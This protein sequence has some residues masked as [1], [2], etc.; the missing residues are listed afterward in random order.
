MSSLEDSA[1][2]IAR[3]AVDAAGYEVVNLKVDGRR[4]MRIWIDHDPDGVKVDDCV[5][6]NR[7]VLHALGDQGIDSG[8]FHVEVLSPGLDRVLTRDKDYTRFAGSQVVV[9]LLQKRGDRRKWRGRLIGLVNGKITIK[10]D[11][12][13]HE[14]LG[15]AKDEIDEIR[16]VPNLSKK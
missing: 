12:P 14:D 2:A 13:P 8:A 7:A 9:Q 5:R 4:H 10:N 16:I 11:D 1:V 15:F 6:V 3:Q